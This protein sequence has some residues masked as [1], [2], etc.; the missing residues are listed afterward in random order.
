[1]PVRLT[2]IG[3]YYEFYNCK[4][5]NFPLF[6]EKSRF[7]DDTVLT[8]AVADAFMNKKDYAKTFKEYAKKYPLAGF[9][10]SFIQWVDG[11]SM[12]P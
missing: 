12:L 5:T 6:C 10:G 9:G 3:S 11:D 1:L 8:V 2:V 7:T 4:S